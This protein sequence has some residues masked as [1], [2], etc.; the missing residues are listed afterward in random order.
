MRERAP[1]FGGLALLA[2]AFV[3]GAYFIGDGIRD[4]NKNDVIVVTGS[5]KKRIVSDYVVW[6]ASVTSAQRSA[7]DAAKERER[8]TTAIRSFLKREGVQGGE[9]SVQPI[10]TETS[11]GVGENRDGRTCLAMA[12][13]LSAAAC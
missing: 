4:R 9:I 7:T 12:V 10:S 2:V 6:D 1:I 5:A 13:K 8:W 11:S 3:I